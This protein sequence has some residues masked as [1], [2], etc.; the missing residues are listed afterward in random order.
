MEIQTWMN[1]MFGG[2]ALLI[3]GGGMLMMFT[4]VFT[5]KGPQPEDPQSD[6]KKG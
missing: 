1:W 4:T 2:L 3:L 5:T 6:S